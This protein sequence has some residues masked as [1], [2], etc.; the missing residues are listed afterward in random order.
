MSAREVNELVSQSIQAD[1]QR[2]FV[3]D[4][5]VWVVMTVFVAAAADFVYTIATQLLI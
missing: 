3:V 5:A 4:V 2:D 1:N